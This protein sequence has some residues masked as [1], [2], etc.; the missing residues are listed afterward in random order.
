MISNLQP[1]TGAQHSAQARALEIGAGL[2]RTR[3]LMY[4]QT[5]SS[6][7]WPFLAVLVFW[8][9]VLFMASA[10]SRR[11]TEPCSPPCSSVRSPLPA[12]SS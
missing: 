2:S 9:V 6:I 8:L 3:V 4:E 12:R 5:G 10:C 7:A 11:P 1:Q